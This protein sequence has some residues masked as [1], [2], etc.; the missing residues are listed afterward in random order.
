MFGRWVCFGVMVSMAGVAGAD[1]P[2]G[3]ADRNRMEARARHIFEEAD[4]DHSGSLSQSEQVEAGLRAETEIQQLLN[5]H[6]SKIL[7][8]VPEPKLADREAMTMAEFIQHFESLA[9]RMDATVRTQRIASRRPR[10]RGAPTPAPSA[11]SNTV[12]YIGEFER[13]R[14]V[15]EDG[16]RKVN[17][18]YPPGSEPIS[19]KDDVTNPSG[20]SSQPASGGSSVPSNPGGP[21]QK[22]GIKFPDVPKN[23]GNSRENPKGNGGGGFEK[24]REKDKGDRLREKPTEKPKDKDK[25]PKHDGRKGNK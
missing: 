25:D 2:A 8:A 6:H 12:I 22:K 16:P 9:G 11:G 18:I 24:L 13:I 10:A 1:I 14:D 15:D 17:K 4:A 19:V 3:Q 7:P 5:E 23:T 21:D 20:N